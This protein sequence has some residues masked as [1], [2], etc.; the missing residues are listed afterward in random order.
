MS[1]SLL[2]S[3]LEEWK[4]F[5]RGFKIG[6][7][8]G[9]GGGVVVLVLISRGLEGRRKGTGEGA[10]DAEL[11]ES[12]GGFREKEIGVAVEEENEEGLCLECKEKCECEVVNEKQKASIVIV[13]GS[14]E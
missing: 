3:E 2:V 9:F 7:G 4:G 5:L 13:Y 11:L 14:R 10:G 12:G 8:L 6:A 1:Q